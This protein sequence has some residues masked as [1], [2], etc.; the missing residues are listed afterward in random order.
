MKLL[1]A[2]L[3][4]RYIHSS[5]A[6]PSIAAAC[7]QVPGLETVIREHT[8]NERPQDILK[9]LMS[10]DADIAA[11]SCYIWNVEQ[12]LKLAAEMKLLNPGL[13]LILGG[14]EASYGSRDLMSANP[15]IDAVVHG[16]GEETMNELLLLFAE[17][18]GV[19]IHDDL[20]SAVPGIS[21][22]SGYELITT[23][24]RIDPDSL[25]SM[26]SPFAAG[27]ADLSK[28]LVYY[29][30]SRGCPFSCA[31]C[32]SS[33]DK[34]VRTF[35]FSRIEADLQIL[36]EHGV[37]TIK[38]VDR[39][40]NYDAERANR[41][42]EF[43]LA[44]NRTSRFHFEIAADLLTDENIAILK[45]VPDETFRFE[46]GV[47]SIAAETL[48]VVGR[49]SNL[50]KLFSNVRRVTDETGITIHLDL[51]AGLPGE[52]FEGFVRS[53][54]RLV[55]ARPHHIQVEPLKLLKGTQMRK[56]ARE[57]DYT[58]SPFPPYRILNNPWLT[59]AE[60][61]R[62][63]ECAEALDEIYNSSRFA[64]TLETV[65]LHHPLTPL[66]TSWTPLKSKGGRLSL[67]FE[68]FL[69]HL[70]KVSPGLSEQIIEPL[71]FD[72]CMNGHPG[73]SIPS[74]LERREPPEE[75]STSPASHKE[76]ASRLSLN[77]EI[78]FRTFS[79]N[80]TRDYTAAGWPEGDTRITFVYCGSGKEQKILHLVE[81]A[82]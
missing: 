11:F 48:D 76:I 73:H 15:H 7:L 46:I 59:F 51:V 57:R 61:C 37:E 70:E 40:F 6:L 29:E 19:A 26:P 66:F 28:P 32:L 82:G 80:F 45:K 36:M 31:F 4:S 38:F 18:P 65:S 62:I 44:N 27:L 43:I 34:G 52:D 2:T 9:S 77:Q 67:I 30:S 78:R 3:H 49:R 72:Y 47:Q 14:P 33:I 39:T 74:F 17:N 58:F 8:V 1:L 42:W 13:Y 56:I 68:S 21:F 5:L 79:A 71:L 69:N 64:V 53:L 22:R 60:I 12:T 24:A 54:D 16:E 41:I 35:S 63:E 50:D 23:P 75:L 20:L 25:D 55:T 10:E 81:R